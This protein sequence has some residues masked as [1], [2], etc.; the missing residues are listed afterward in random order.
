MARLYE[1]TTLSIPF[2][3]RDTDPMFAEGVLEEIWD[4][5]KR[6]RRKSARREERYEIQYPLKGVVVSIVVRRE[7]PA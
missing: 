7:T 5:V 6:V 2:Q 1:T 3:D 4:M